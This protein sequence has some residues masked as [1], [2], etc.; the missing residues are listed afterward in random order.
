MTFEQKIS[1]YQKTYPEAYGCF[2]NMKNEAIS[3]DF[4]M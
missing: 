2:L 1:K 4:Y 3:L